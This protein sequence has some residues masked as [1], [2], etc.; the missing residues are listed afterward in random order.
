MSIDVSSVVGLFQPTDDY[1]LLME[2][3]CVD[4]STSKF[5]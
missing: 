3:W 4:D 5:T 1:C 2:L